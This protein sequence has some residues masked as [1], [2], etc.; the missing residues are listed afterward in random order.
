MT[1]MQAVY[2]LHPD[3][4]VTY[5]FYCRNVHQPIPLHRTDFKA[6]IKTV[7][8]ELD[9]LCGLSFS[10]EEIA[11]L[12]SFPFFHSDFLSWLAKFR[13]SRDHIIL[14]ED[15]KGF[16][17]IRIDGP[18]VR[19][20]LFEVP[21]L[22]IVSSLYARAAYGE[23]SSTLSEGRRR[24]ESKIDG[25]VSMQKRGELNHF[26]FVDMGTRRRFSGPWQAHVLERFRDAC[27][28][29]FMG[30][31]NAYYAKKLGMD[32]YGTMAHEWLQAYQ[33]I[34][35]DFRSF[36]KDAL[37]DW[38]REYPEHLGIALSDV[39]GFRVFLADFDSDLAGRYA[40]VRHDSGD[41]LAFGRLLIDHY[42]ELGIDPAGK[43]AVFSDGLDFKTAVF[44]YHT[45]EHRIPMSFGIGTW[46]TNDMGRMPLQIVIKM[47]H[48]NGLPVLKLSDS[49][50]KTTCEDMDFQNELKTLFHVHPL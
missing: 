1:M 37:M 12:R 25:L 3:A 29:L 20:I 19:T 31:S 17:S 11:Y 48:F 32:C 47:T 44:I 34:S 24:L 18:W 42:L 46:L 26:K 6:W 41:P 45:F 35:R 7:D 39:L 36:Q 40:G 10:Q 2:H 49:V 30:T 22:A 33:R 38:L 5:T 13:L 50:G 16:L 15:D 21:M 8:R 14:S 43:T 4:S 23:E 28:A 27:P 9:H